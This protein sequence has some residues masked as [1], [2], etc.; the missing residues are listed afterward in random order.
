VKAQV[1][2]ALINYASSQVYSFM[3]ILDFFFS[4][5]RHETR[6]IEQYVSTTVTCHA[7]VTSR[8]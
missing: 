3:S 1:C 7:L 4:F 5:K 2:T 8:V 6:E